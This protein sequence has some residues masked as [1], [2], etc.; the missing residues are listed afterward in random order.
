MK[1]KGAGGWQVGCVVVE[2]ET[3]TQEPGGETYRMPVRT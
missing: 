3:S 1:A 2:D